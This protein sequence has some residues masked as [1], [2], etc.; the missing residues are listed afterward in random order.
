VRDDQGGP[1][2]V[3]EGLFEPEHRGGIEVVRGLVEQQDVGLGNQRLREGHPSLLAARELPHGAIPSPDPETAQADLR[4][5]PELPSSLSFERGCERCLTCQKALHVA[6]PLLKCHHHRVIGLKGG[7]HLTRTARH[8][9]QDA[10]AGIHDRLLRQVP[11]AEAPAD[12]QRALVHPFLPRQNAEEG[13]LAAPV[14][15]DQADLFS[16]LER[17]VNPV[18]QPTRTMGLPESPKVQ[19]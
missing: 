15:S 9:V 19:H 18:E 16:L 1:R 6:L 14:A 13:R 11:H 10:H 4:T 2:K 3:V 5:V 17:K 12:G 7:R 8:G